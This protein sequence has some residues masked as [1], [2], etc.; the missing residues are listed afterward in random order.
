MASITRQKQELAEQIED[1]MYSYILRLG[2][3]SLED[4]ALVMTNAYVSK[5]TL[6]E[7][8]RYVERLKQM[9]EKRSGGQVDSD[10]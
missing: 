8:K 10:A 9:K 7:R 5:L 2:R 1:E 6:A 4:L 3:E